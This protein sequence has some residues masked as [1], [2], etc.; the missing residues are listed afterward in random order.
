LTIFFGPAS[1]EEEEMPF[2]DGVERV[3]KIVGIL[4]G[5][6]AVTGLWVTARDLNSKE[7][8]KRV[9]EWQRSIVY[10]LIEHNPGVKFPDLSRYYV[11]EAQKLPAQIPSEQVGDEHL[12]L[13]VLAL[14]QNNAIVVAADNGYNVKKESDPVKDL[15]EA[16]EEYWNVTFGREAKA[17]DQMT[18]L[19]DII[20]QYDG[21]LSRVEL[22]DKALNAPGND[23]ALINIGFPRFIFM[24]LGYGQISEDSNGKLHYGRISR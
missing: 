18:I 24:M 19:A 6:A 3:V 16:T 9:D 15:A 17:N 11:S 13:A 8:A 1:C 21:K 5:L 4:G 7:S 22:K 20:K 12:R 23:K 2:W 14:I 10:E